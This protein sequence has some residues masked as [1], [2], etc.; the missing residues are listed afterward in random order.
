MRARSLAPARVGRPEH[1]YS[2]SECCEE[3]IEVGRTKVYNV[4]MAESLGTFE[5]A[6]LLSVHRLSERAYGRP[7]IKDLELRLGRRVSA[8][9]AYATLNRLEERGLLIS[10]LESGAPERGGRARRF[11]RLA[12]SGI[13]ALDE[14][15]VLTAALWRGVKWRPKRRFA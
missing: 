13:D 11:Y 5:Q 6:V 14:S 12:S 1:S 9:A 8:G 4:G 10:R 3:D 15:R 7:V 2:G